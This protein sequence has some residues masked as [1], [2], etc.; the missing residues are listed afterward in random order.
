MSAMQQDQASQ[1]RALMQRDE[2]GIGESEN[3]SDLGRLEESVLG[4]SADVFFRSATRDPKFKI[5][6]HRSARVLAIASGKG[7]V[8]KTNIA[9]NL[10]LCMARMGQR[11]VLIDADLGTANIDVIMNVH[12]PYDLSHV[13]RRERSLE[14]AMVYVERGLQLVVGASGLCG[15]ADLTTLQRQSIIDQL[16]CLE[17]SADIILLDCG[18]GISQ[19]VL[20]FARAADE[21]MIVT[22]PEP[23]ALTDAY[24][25]IKVL[26]LSNCTP[27][28]DLVV[29]QAAT[30]REGRMIADRIAGVASRFL[31][32]GLSCSGQILHDPHVH[33]AV[34][35]RTP[36]ISRYPRCP[37]STCI[38][39][40]ADRI[41]G[42]AFAL[43][44]R[45]GFFHRLTRFFY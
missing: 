15:I 9:V 22:T 16:T 25:L 41:V 2:T 42:H 38:T 7:G 39:M 45:T 3:Y 24:A 20:A 17:T 35:Q 27:P 33:Q 19:N 8:G 30:E 6:K 23:T 26:S 12:S 44:S 1:L 29:N 36:F 34:C 10:A 11:V 21:L 40:L 13:I 4:K 18:A 31:H 5:D 37:A 43:P 32:T 14:D 28:M